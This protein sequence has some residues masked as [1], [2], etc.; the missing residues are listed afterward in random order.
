MWG[1]QHTCSTPLRTPP[2]LHFLFLKSKRTLR[3]GWEH[4]AHDGKAEIKILGQTTVEGK[5]RQAL[6][7]NAVSLQSRSAYWE[8]LL[9]FVCV[10]SSKFLFEKAHGNHSHFIDKKNA[11]Y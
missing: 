6:N 5:N 8:S 1:W 9:V 10:S 11:A 2:F 3:S 7:S 4:E